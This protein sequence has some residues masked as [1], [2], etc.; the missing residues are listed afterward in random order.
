MYDAGQGTNQLHI[1]SHEPEMSKKTIGLKSR[2]F[3]ITHE[4][5]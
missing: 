5:Y 4:L 3:Y 2:N 1:L